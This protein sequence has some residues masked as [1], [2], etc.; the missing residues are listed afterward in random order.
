[1]NPAISQLQVF[2]TRTGVLS[3]G[4]APAHWKREVACETD[5]LAIDLMKLH[6]QLKLTKIVVSE[7]GASVYSASEFASR[8]LPELDVSLRG[9]VSIARRLQDP[10]AELVKIDPKSIGVGQYQHD[11]SQTQLARQLDAVVEDC[12]NAVGVDVNTASAPLLAR[13]SGLS[14][15]VAQS[16]VNY[17]D[18]QGAFASRAA[19]KKVPRLGDKT[20]ELAAGFL[21]IVNGDNPLDAS[22]VHPESYPVVEKIL[23][24]IQKDIKAVIGD[25]ALVKRL[26][27]AKYADDKFGVPTVTD[28]LK[29]LEKP[30]RDPR[31][32]FTTATF[33]EGV[34]EIS[35]LRPDM[36]LEGVVTNVAAFGAFVDIG[37]HQDGLVH[38]SALSNSFVKDPHTVVKAGQVVKVKVLEV[39]VKRKRIA[40]TMR[41]SD[42]APQAGSQPN[43]RADRDDRKRMADHQNKHQKQERSAPAGGAMAAAFAKLKR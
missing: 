27:P 26:N 16:I 35:D 13:V 38:I 43:Q 11:V 18:Q 37:V 7:A 6:P 22:A 40:L 39:D 30:G 2:P 34:E 36:I 17:R 19:L 33:K 12:V 42:S 5:R 4:Q 29:E 24:D 1:M 25:S 31:P 14:S 23:A 3:C 20:F 8:E 10:L 28:I 21:R 9:A 41:L 15:S 32:E